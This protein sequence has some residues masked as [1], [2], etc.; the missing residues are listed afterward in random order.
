MSV[1]FNPDERAAVAAAATKP[2]PLRV[3]AWHAPPREQPE[4]ERDWPEPKPLPNG[5]PR[6]DD[7]SL[8]FLPDAL[9]PW[10]EDITNRLQCPP[11][12]VAVA[13]TTALGS[14]IGVSELDRKRKRIGLKYRICGG[15]LSA[16]L[17][18]S[19]PLL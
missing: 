11:D 10:V 19:N 6:V 4:R 14:V 17:G 13:A 5:L 16:G 2:R 12:Y 15:C 18:C 3:D 9:A 8:E 1:S 7:F